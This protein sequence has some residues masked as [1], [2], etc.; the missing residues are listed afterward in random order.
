M[1][2]IDGRFK[3][4]LL[5][6]AEPFFGSKAAS[7]CGCPKKTATFPFYFFGWT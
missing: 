2:L 7:D 1:Q 5:L 4:L 6:Q 3:G